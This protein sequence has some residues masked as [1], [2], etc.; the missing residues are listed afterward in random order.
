LKQSINTEN[1]GL[2]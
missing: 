2:F 1:T